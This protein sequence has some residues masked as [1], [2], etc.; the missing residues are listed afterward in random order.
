MMSFAPNGTAVDSLRIQVGDNVEEIK[1]DSTWKFDVKSSILMQK[2]TK[3][4]YKINGKIEPKIFGDIEPVK[5]SVIIQKRGKDIFMG[6]ARDDG[7]LE[8]YQKI[9]AEMRDE[10]H[11]KAQENTQ[12]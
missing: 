1:Q 9:T 10:I 4:T 5:V 11:K 6:L 3:I 8:I 2:I 12:K 7:T